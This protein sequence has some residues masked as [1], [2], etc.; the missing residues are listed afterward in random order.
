MIFQ[1]KDTETKAHSEKSINVG[2]MKVTDENDSLSNSMMIKAKK[3]LVEDRIG[4]NCAVSE[5]VFQPLH[6][7]TDTPSYTR[8]VLIAV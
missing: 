3:I 7:D 5:I 1:L 2:D 4:I 8:S 6:S